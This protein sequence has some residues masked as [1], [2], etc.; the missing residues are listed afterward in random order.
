[1]ND[2]TPFAAHFNA[3]YPSYTDERY[4]EISAIVRRY[5]DVDLPA[6]LE[7]SKFKPFFDILEPLILIKNYKSQIPF[8]RDLSAA[9][10]CIYGIRTTSVSVTS[11]FNEHEHLFKQLIEVQGF[12]LPTV[13]AVF[14]F[15]HPCHFPIVDRNVEAACVWLYSN[16]PQD[17][18]D[19]P[20]PVLPKPHE[21]PDAKLA[22]YRDFVAFLSKVVTLQRRYSP[23]ADYRFAD[24]AL[25]VLGAQRL[26]EQRR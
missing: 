21:K 2:L 14:H 24:K 16:H 11:I 13:S 3:S 4:T 8:P 18:I 17:F 9:L 6:L 1:M 20:L 22:R 5:G 26:R 7:D 12:Q 25:M 10:S 19:L 15:C 23:S